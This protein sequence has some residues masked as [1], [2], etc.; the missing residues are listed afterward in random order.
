[1]A[2][3]IHIVEVGPR[4]GLQSEQSVLSTATKVEFI[5]RILACGIRR[6]EVA[7]FVNPK[8]VPQMADAEAVISGLQR[9]DGSSFIG[10]VMNR[11]GFERARDAAVDEVGFVVVASET[12]NKR[13][14]GVSIDESIAAWQ[15]I[16]RDAR[17]AG[18]RAG[19]MISA[20]FGC[21]YEGEISEQVV[22]EIA[23]RVLSAEP[24]EVALADSIGVGVPSQVSSLVGQL[25]DTA[26]GI[27]I[28]CHFHNTRNTGLAN[29]YAAVEAGATSLDAS[30]GGMGGCPFAPAASGN[31][32][33]ED[34]V[35]MLHR[36][37]I[38]TGA[39][40]DKIIDTSNWLQEQLGHGLPAMLPKAGSFPES[41]G[42]Q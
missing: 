40:L 8:R 18:M 23:K 16:A 3:P 20:A 38:D 29:A 24:D 25:R 31:I 28:R 27:P 26:S 12:Y 30:I 17:S 11:R 36:S 9:T 19:I 41:V 4:D 34:L 21:P 2:N 6:V 7:S 33:T 10:L 22:M 13:N 32:P 14:Q 37:S 5:H 42:A 35:Y 39:Q 1:M 15:Q